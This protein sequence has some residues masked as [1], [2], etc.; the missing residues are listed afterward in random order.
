MWLC[1]ICCVL[2]DFKLLEQWLDGWCGA[3][4][5]ALLAR[6]ADGDA[7]EGAFSA[8]EPFL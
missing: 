4:R 8:F 3:T 5:I 6:L 2:L 7:C 1:V